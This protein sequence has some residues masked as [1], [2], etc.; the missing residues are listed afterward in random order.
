MGSCL[1]IEIKPVLAAESGNDFQEQIGGG[2]LAGN[3]L[4]LNRFRGQAEEVFYLLLRENRLS[5]LCTGKDNGRPLGL[6]RE[7]R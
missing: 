7:R 1:N 2:D 6:G 3:S 5:L 4:L